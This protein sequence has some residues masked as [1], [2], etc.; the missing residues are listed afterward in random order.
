MGRIIK[1]SEET[2]EL[3]IL[4][5]G[6][7]RISN[8]VPWCLFD[9]EALFDMKSAGRKAWYTFWRNVRGFETVFVPNGKSI[10]GHR[11]LRR[12]VE[13]NFQIDCTNSFI[14]TFL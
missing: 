7:H 12:Y 5:A 9:G 1:C 13:K 11:I 8:A 14:Q 2:C 6:E 3:Q 10:K 4:C